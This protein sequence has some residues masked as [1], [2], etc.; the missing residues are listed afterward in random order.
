M[1]A[2]VIIE[3]AIYTMALI[4]FL[5]G[6]C[7]LWV[8]VL[9]WWVWLP[10]YRLMRAFSRACDAADA[11]GVPEPSPPPF[12]DPIWDRRECHHHRHKYNHQAR[13]WRWRARDDANRS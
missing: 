9:T 12:L 3:A 7:W 1:T 4:A 2:I 8:A 5:A 6:V 11:A 13:K 10:V